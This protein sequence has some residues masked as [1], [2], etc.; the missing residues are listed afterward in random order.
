VLFCYVW[1]DQESVAD[2]YEFSLRDNDD[3]FKLGNEG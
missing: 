3:G 1:F 2:F